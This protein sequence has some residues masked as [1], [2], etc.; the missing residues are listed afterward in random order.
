MERQWSVSMR[1]AVLYFLASRIS[2]VQ[3]GPS[4]GLAREDVAEPVDVLDFYRVA[5]V[6]VEVADD[7]AGLVHA[8]DS[9]TADFDNPLR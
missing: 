8:A 5:T 2:I 7:H 3:P 4:D 6:D 1:F 9:L